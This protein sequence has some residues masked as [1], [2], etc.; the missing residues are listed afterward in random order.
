MNTILVMRRLD[1]I[2][3]RPMP[4]TEGAQSPFFSPDSRWIGFI[5]M[6][7][8]KKISVEG[9]AP[10]TLAEIPFALTALWG[11][12]DS[13]YFGGFGTGI[14][15]ISASGG[16]P[17]T[18]VEFQVDSESGSLAM[19]PLVYLPQSGALLF[20]ATSSPQGL[21][22]R[23]DSISLESG[24]R[25]TLIR[26]ARSAVYTPTGHLVYTQLGQLMAAPFDPERLE[27]TGPAVPVTE[28]RMATPKTMPLAVSFSSDG[29]LLYTPGGAARTENRVLVWV[30]REGNETPIEA[31]TNT[32]GSLSLSPDADRIVLG[33]GLGG[34]SNVW[35]Y[36]LKMGTLQKLTFGAG[37]NSFPVWSHD[38][39][40]VAFSSTR[41][42]QF[43][44]FWKAANGIGEVHRLTSTPYPQIPYYWSPDEVALVYNT[45]RPETGLDIGIV[46]FEDESKSTMIFEDASFE[47]GAAVSPDG[48]W[49]AYSSSAPGRQEVFVHPFPDVEAGRWQ[50]SN[51]GG[52]FPL[53]SPDGRELFYRSDSIMRV[54]VETDPAFSRSTPEAL[55][56]NSYIAGPNS[57]DMSPDGQRFLMIKESDGSE[58]SAAA[59]ELIIVENWFEVLKERAPIGK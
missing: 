41:E 56:E 9:G 15:R 20:N 40:K 5:T 2:D 49:I 1:R 27:L 39:E 33:V 13:I 4:G 12:D 31:E 28:E 44:L 16:T 53:W 22:A 55:F 29:S 57:Y 38:G 50:I 46:S 32:Y 42:G 8:I 54:S 58:P 3:G 14:R 25:K 6:N 10:I 36:D 23:I 34:E 21:P 45:L 47:T 48:R 51:R 52:S 18:I 17:E 24:E 30:D 35:I 59:D 37:A 7:A 26:D 43:N 11:E 19:E